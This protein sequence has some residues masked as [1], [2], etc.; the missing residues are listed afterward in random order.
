MKFAVNR[1]QVTPLNSDL[2]RLKNIDQLLSDADQA[3]RRLKK[4][5][6]WIRLTALGVGAIIGASIFILTGTAAAGE[7]VEYPR[8]SRLLCS[9]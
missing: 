2:F 6:G 3:E 4:T 5:L 1:F 9:K 8:S 7:V